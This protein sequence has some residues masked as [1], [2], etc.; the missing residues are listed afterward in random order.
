[1]FREP[2]SETAINY[3]NILDH[4]ADSIIIIDPS[5]TILCINLKAKEQIFRDT[6]K[7]CS[8]G[9]SIFN[10]IIESRKLL[11]S[12]TLE[13]VC[14]GEVVEYDHEYISES[15]KNIYFHYSIN[16]VYEKGILSS[17][18]I[19]GRDITESK[20]SENKL[21]K[22]E[23]DYQHLFEK[24]PF[25]LFIYDLESCAILEANEAAIVLY[26][27]S[28]DEFLSLTLE[29]IGS[30]KNI[31]SFEEGLS[32]I[33][34]DTGFS[35]GS[36]EH[37]KKN[38]DIIYVEIST[39]HFEFQSTPAILVLIHDITQKKIA[40][41]S[42]NRLANT[43]QILLNS[44]DGI[45]WQADANTFEF[46]FISNA[47]EKILGYT[48]EQ[49][50]ACPSFWE[51][52]ILPEDRGEAL[53][54]CR[55]SISR[56]ESH[57]FEYRMIA[58]DGSLVYIHD[59]VSVIIEND[60]PFML[61]GIMSDITVRKEAELKNEFR[62]RLLNT[63][64]QAVI[65]TNIDGR[66][67]YWNKAAEE[68]Y[69]WTEKEAIGEDV[70]ELLF[71]P[72][73]IAHATEI[74]QQLLLG[75][76]W[77]GE[78]VVKKKNGDEL[79][80]FVT[81]SPY[82]DQHKNILGIIGVSNDITEKKKT[83]EQIIK[84][85]ERLRIAQAVAKV[86]SWETDLSTLNIIWSEETY[87]IFEID[88]KSLNASHFG[89][90]Q[91]VHPGDRENVKKAFD[92]SLQKDYDNSIEHRIITAKGNEKVVEER[93]H[94]LK[95]NEG[96]PIRANGTVQDITEDKKAES[97]LQ[98]SEARL[99]GII[100]SQTNYILRT[101]F[102]GNYTYY[103]QKFFDDFGWVHNQYDLTGINSMSSIMEYHNQRVKKLLLN[104]LQT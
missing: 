27:Y 48:P 65:A 104:V 12:E 3:Q 67:N 15:N 25:P 99:K 89:F 75:Y 101:D 41:D 64:G 50:L 57:K 37:I 54:F 68:I 22:T 38:G 11:F 26:G 28:H 81:N 40:D 53:S 63:I 70:V 13:K 5:G 73:H 71:A 95:D 4:L 35:K 100:A 94:I 102:N 78:Q 61:R 58:A 62:A 42:F 85:E 18:S 9:D 20:I 56:K 32:K 97:T 55:Q 98:Q 79:E 30:Q 24:N 90:L 72:Q 46:T 17:I 88:S 33:N 66:I 51:D 45:V 10:Y 82:Y 1:M 87:N 49:W 6:K 29:Q 23:K 76:S 44:V 2:Q 60:K 93:W 43:Y 47:V 92:E 31:E 103:N 80:V 52:H 96:K 84:S 91:Y 16:P 74:M 14:K 39:L 34:V 69:G 83:E 7:S 19:T 86:G 8:A 36:W 77:S 21:L 59:N